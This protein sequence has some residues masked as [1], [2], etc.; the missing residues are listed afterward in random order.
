MRSFLAPARR[1][2]ARVRDVRGHRP[3]SRGPARARHDDRA[4]AAQD[5]RPLSARREEQE[6]VVAPYIHHSTVDLADFLRTNT[7]LRE[8]EA[9]AG[10]A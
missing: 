5:L 2:P 4:G 1:R 10:A 6:A 8:I 9:V 3:E 7:P